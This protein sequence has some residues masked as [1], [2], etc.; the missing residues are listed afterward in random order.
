ME[1]EGRLS[2]GNYAEGHKEGQ[3]MPS[4]EKTG[5]GTVADDHSLELLSSPFEGCS[6]RVLAHL[7][8]CPI[9]YSTV[10]YLT[11]LPSITT[12]SYSKLCM[13]AFVSTNE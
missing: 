4:L 7:A 2:K 12:A 13:H 8:F 5:D 11:S 6:K 1:L 10:V 3:Y 9:H